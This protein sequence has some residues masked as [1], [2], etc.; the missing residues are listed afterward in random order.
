MALRRVELTEEEMKQSGF[1]PFWKWNAIGD[2][3]KGVFLRTEDTEK[4]FGEGMKAVTLFI[5]RGRTENGEVAEI[6]V[7][8]DSDL[9]QRLLKAMNPEAEG[10]IGL[11][12]GA[13]HLVTM[14]WMKNAP[15]TDRAGAPKFKKIYEVEVDTDPRAGQRPPPPP[16][17]PVADDDIPF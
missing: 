7:T 13:N 10:G 4:D 17:P 12:G 15:Y 1:R 8:P 14:T 11:K 2:M 5:F 16:K 3:H 9:K 6:E